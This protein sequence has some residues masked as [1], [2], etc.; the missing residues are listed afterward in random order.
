LADDEY[1]MVRYRVALH[2][3]CPPEILVRLA[4]DPIRAVRSVAI[5]NPGCPVHIRAMAAMAP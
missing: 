2:A 1:V 3:D 4:R 5:A